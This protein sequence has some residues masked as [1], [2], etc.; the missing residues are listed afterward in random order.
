MWPPDKGPSTRGC[1]LARVYREL[2]NK[3]LSKA[4]SRFNNT[5]CK[6]NQPER[7]LT[8]IFIV[9]HLMPISSVNQIRSHPQ[10]HSPTL[11]WLRQNPTHSLA[12]ACDTAPALPFSTFT[13]LQWLRESYS[14]RLIRPSRKLQKVSRRS[15]A[16]S[17]RYNKLPTRHRKTSWRTR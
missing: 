9:L 2:G 13:Y 8:L 3:L 14:K 5:T 17:T 7:S 12:L 1:S 6:A 16:Y 4:L 11:A 10:Q 15:R